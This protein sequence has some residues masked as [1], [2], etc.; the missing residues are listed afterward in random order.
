M[1]LLMTTRRAAAYVNGQTFPDMSRKTAATKSAAPDILFY[2]TPTLCADLLWLGKFDAP[3]PV[4]AMRIGGKTVAALS[5]LEY[6]RG[7]KTS[8]F[9]EVLPMEVVEA[10]AKA[11]YGDTGHPVARCVRLLAEQRGTKSFTVADDFSTGITLDLIKNGFE[12]TPGALTL[13][14][15]R[16]IKTPDEVEKIREGNACSATGIKRAE[17]VLREATVGKGGVLKWKGKTLTSELLRAEIVKACIDAGGMAEGTIVAGG[18]Q[19]VD[20]HERGSGPLRANEF[21]IVDVF[22]RMLSTLYCGDMT[23]TFLKGKATPA[24][25]KQYAAVKAAHKRGL[26]AVRADRHGSEI[27]SD[28]VQSFE[29]NGYKSGRDDT[30]Y[31]GFYHGTGHGLGLE[32]HEPLRMRGWG[33]HMIR[34]GMVVTVEPGL[35]YLGKGGARIEDVVLVTKTGCQMISKYHYKW[36]IA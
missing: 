35:Y 2:A 36:E 4:L 25:R 20:C 19:A 13:V 18:D 9:D 27:H 30:G 28:V 23:R 15:E 12:I 10:E 26:E 29:E 32:I 7:V 22:P 34:E 11:K 6:S 24:Q 8:K 21:I 31:F 1:A 3:D 33:S 14:P 5:P 16:L 17:T